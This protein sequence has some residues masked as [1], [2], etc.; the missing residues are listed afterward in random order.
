MGQHDLM[1]EV[2][3]IAEVTEEATRKRVFEWFIKY[4]QWGP[5]S[6]GFHGEVPTLDELEQEWRADHES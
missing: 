6:E 4:S 5:G 1:K 2:Q 3:M